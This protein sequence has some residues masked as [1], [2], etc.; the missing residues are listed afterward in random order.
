MAWD[1]LLLVIDFKVIQILMLPVVY[2]SERQGH[3]IDYTTA[4]SAKHMNS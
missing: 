3:D 2:G 1:K 4:S